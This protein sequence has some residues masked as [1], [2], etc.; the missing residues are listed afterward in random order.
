VSNQAN[1]FQGA[2]YKYSV[3]Q[4]STNFQQAPRVLINVL[5]RL[6]WAGRNAVQA[7]AGTNKGDNEFKPFN[8]ILSIG[9]IEESK[10]GVSF[11]SGFL[12]TLC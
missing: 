4:D 2:P 1:R 6:T 5:K 3:A 9:Y 11:L 8:E 12:N 7:V 10:M